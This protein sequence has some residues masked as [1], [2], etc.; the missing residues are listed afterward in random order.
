MD[1]SLRRE[2]EAFKKRALAATEKSQKFREAAAKN[3]TPVEYVS[4]P[5][6]SKRKG[7]SSQTGSSKDKTLE[8]IKDAAKQAHRNENVHRVLKCIMDML[9][10]NYINKKDLDR[11]KFEEILCVIG[12]SDIRSDMRQWLRDALTSNTKVLFSREEDSFIFKPA[13]GHHVR[14]KKQ[15]LTRLQD[16]DREGLGGITM[17][18]ICEA[19]PKPEK[20]VKVSKVCLIVQPI[21]WI[22]SLMM[23]DT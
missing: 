3:R 15:L 12:L 16:Y 18:D 8:E 11:M 7:L 23:G 4:K 10:M 5:Q 6:K 20:T 9:K 19:I 2:K 13:L 1:P 21:I 14:G 22:S 17:T